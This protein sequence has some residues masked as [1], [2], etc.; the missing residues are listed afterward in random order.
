[1]Q[2]HEIGVGV[3]SVELSATERQTKFGVS[4]DEVNVLSGRSSQRSVVAVVRAAYAERP[5]PPL[6]ASQPKSG[7]RLSRKG[8][9]HR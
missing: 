8:A 2:A 1:M 5:R 4:P 9:S 7:L 3:F 6:S